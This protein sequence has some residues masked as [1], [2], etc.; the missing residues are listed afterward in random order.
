[1]SSL[2]PQLDDLLTGRLPADDRLRIEE[3]LAGCEVCRAEWERLTATR[4]LLRHSSEAEEVPNDVEASV[5]AVLR[6]E[7]GRVVAFR[8]R[9]MIGA[10]IAAALLIAVLLLLRRP[11]GDLPAAAIHDL[12]SVSSGS[13]PLELRT[14]DTKQMQ[15]WFDARLDFSTRVFDFGMMRYQLVGGRIDKVGEHR[16]ALFVYRH[17][18][19]ALV[20]CQMF[21]GTTEELPRGA[22]R[23]SHN[24]IDFFIYQRG[25]ATAVF[26]QEGPVVCVLASTI[27]SE[28]AISLAFA[29]AMKPTSV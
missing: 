2:H 21:R 13:V 15:R 29:K 6:R 3:H 5:S 18:N 28:E 4:E 9:V 20:V 26:W 23:R 10:T 25:P 7:S 1:M 12:R 11:S 17:A 22:H 19:G 24:G 8:R 14:E 27:P 16:S